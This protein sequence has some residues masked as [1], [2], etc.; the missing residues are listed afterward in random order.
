LPATDQM[1]D[2]RLGSLIVVLIGLKC[3]LSYVRLA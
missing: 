1:K 3:L 2:E